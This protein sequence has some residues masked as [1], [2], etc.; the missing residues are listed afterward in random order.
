MKISITCALLIVVIG[1]LI[2]WQDHRRF[3][4]VSKVHDELVKEASGL[5]IAIDAADP[6]AI[7]HITKHERADHRVSA[8]DTAAAKSGSRRRDDVVSLRKA[9]WFHL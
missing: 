9:G 5:G 7:P 8:K 2:G 3:F 1:G 6:K 4:I